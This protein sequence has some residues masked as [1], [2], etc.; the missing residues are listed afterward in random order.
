M[1]KK[2]IF[3]NSSNN[4]LLCENVQ[5]TAK[6]TSARTHFCTQYRWRAYPFLHR[7][8]IQTS[9]TLQKVVS[10]KH[11]KYV[12]NHLDETRRLRYVS[13]ESELFSFYFWYYYFFNL[14]FQQFWKRCFQFD[15]VPKKSMGRAKNPKKFQNMLQHHIFTIQCQKI[16]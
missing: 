6:K 12:R 8:Q 14:D 11:K 15:L 4:Q 1:Y 7:C 9:T 2:D 10:L 3:H 5:K 16:C 13:L